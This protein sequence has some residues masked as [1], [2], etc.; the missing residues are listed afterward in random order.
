MMLKGWVTLLGSVAVGAV[1]LAD[2]IVIGRMENGGVDVAVGETETISN[3]YPL[4]RIALNL[5]QE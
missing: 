5:R 1:A 3:S 2:G 4:D